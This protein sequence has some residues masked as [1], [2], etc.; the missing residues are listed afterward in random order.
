ML[1]VGFSLVALPLAASAGTSLQNL[2]PGSPTLY[3][4]QRGEHVTGR[5][6]DM[7][8]P[9][10]DRSPFAVEVIPRDI[11]R[12]S[13][14]V[15]ST[16]STFFARWGSVSAATGYRL[17]VSQQSSF[18]SYVDGYRDLDV[19]DMTG[20]VVTGLSPR[21]KYYYRVRA[22][23]AAGTSA[24]SQVMAGT[25]ASGAGLI[26]NATF[27][28]TITTNPNS[29]AIQSMITQAV[30]IF[31]N[32]FSDP[33]TVSILFRYSASEPDGNP[34]GGLAS[35]SWVFYSIPWNTYIS[36]LQA[37]AT[38]GN[39]TTA[40]ASLPASALSANVNPSSANGRAIGLNTPPGLAANGNVGT[41]P[42]FIYDGIVTLNSSDPFQFTRPVNSGNYDAQ[43]SIEHEIDE[44]LG[45]GSHL[46]LSALR[47]QDLFS[48]STPGT[49]NLTSSGTRYFSID[50]GNTD[51]VD[52]NQDPSRDFGD[53]LSPACPQPNP[54]VQNAFGC[55]GQSSDVSAGSP[56]GISLDV[57]GY[58]LATPAT[59]G[60]ASLVNI[61][62]RMLVL[63]GDNVL[64]GGFVVSGTTPKQVLVRAIGP[65]LA[66]FGVPNPLQDPVLDL[67]NAN[68]SIALN[69]DWQTDPNSGQIPTNLSPGDSRESAILITLQPG[70][71]TAIVSGKNGTSGVGLV[72]VYSMDNASSSQLTNVSTRG[73]VQTGDFVMI[74]GF[75]SS[76]PNGS[77]A[78]LLIRAIGPS[79][80]QFGVTGVLADPTLRL[81]DG[82]GVTIAFD[83]NWRDTQ[84][85]AIQATGN[86]PG[87][88]LESAILA[89]LSPG[90]YTAIVEGNNGGT[91]VGLVELFKLR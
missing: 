20:R 83:D 58:N 50:S 8:T 76:A 5:E 77:S 86:A 65:T 15:V 38:S 63:T 45:L 53:W 2:A 14:P 52:F 48:W 84:E 40:N 44:V 62:T 43:R 47:P 71:Y 88:D 10:I 11:S 90:S 12:S 72:E 29:V 82:N 30:S 89:T 56:E 91:G 54:R 3:R 87:S 46:N 4:P 51:I 67:H 18:S 80:A 37:D 61:S 26:I 41:G 32:L 69:D 19:G 33:I 35:S 66:N 34:V 74:G 24:D 55:A 27:D 36:A 6:E 16:G 70:S 23:N 78:E 79:L 64:I 57:I 22:Y 85:A 21:T 13:I 31:E 42:D 17:D 1:R 7:Q 49:R 60:S 75:I 25:T 28:S 73:S 59:T 81:I 68:T 9:P 39:D